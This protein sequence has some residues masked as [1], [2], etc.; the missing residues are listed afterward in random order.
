[1]FGTLDECLRNIYEVRESAERHLRNVM[2]NPEYYADDWDDELIRAEQYVAWAEQI[3]VI[4]VE[5]K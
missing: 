3:D 5:S 2:V 1:M 4:V